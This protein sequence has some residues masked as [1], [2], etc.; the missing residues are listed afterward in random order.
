MLACSAIRCHLSAPPAAVERW[1]TRP[2][3][4]R[5]FVGTSGIPLLRKSLM[6]FISGA[7]ARG[8]SFSKTRCPHH[9]KKAGLTLRCCDEPREQD[10]ATCWMATNL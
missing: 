9:Q 2:G 4:H 3:K 6:L 5:D 8:A 1:D 7:P 10:C